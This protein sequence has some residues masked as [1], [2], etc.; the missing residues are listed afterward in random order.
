MNILEELYFG[1]IRPDAKFYGKDSEFS[2][3]VG[4]REKNREKL[5]VS[6][7]ENEQEIFEKFTDVQ[8]ELDDMT[9]YEKFSTGFKL[10][11]MLMVETFTIPR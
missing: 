11:V 2:E 7:N 10:G 3:L 6:L 1:N 8:A 9:R 4:L 5:L